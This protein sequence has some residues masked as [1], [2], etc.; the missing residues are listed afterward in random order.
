VW[1]REKY[2][3][4]SI[5]TEEMV[6]DL[7]QGYAR[8][9]TTV[10]D[11]EGGIATGT[12]TETRKS[13]EDFVEKAE[14]RSIGRALAAL[15]IGT[16]FVGE[17]L[18]EGEHV[19]DAP[20]TLHVPSSTPSPLPAGESLS[21]G[22]AEGHPSADEITKLVDAAR[23]ANVDL[24]AF[25]HDMRRLMQLPERHR[26]TKKFL[27]ET[28]TMDQYNTARA[29]YDEALRQVLEADVP[30]HEP[31]TENR[32]A[33]PSATVREATMEPPA[34]E[35]SPAVPFASSSAPANVHA[36]VDAAEGDRQRLRAEVAAWDL[37]LSPQEIE[38]V[39]QH[40][41]Y[42]K[43]RALLWKCRW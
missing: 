43:A 8:F 32:D 1:F 23:A 35:D 15:G 37:R 25:G 10:G 30:N 2:P 28:M 11:G 31:P 36:E 17:E 14:T 26:I 40:N 18:S 7:E 6:V 16:Q 3:H 19:A 5:I 20:V 21:P 9:K 42:S 29:H 13:F 38:H 12:G 39:I 27:R 22:P 34:G 24:E 4:G 41:P 33:D